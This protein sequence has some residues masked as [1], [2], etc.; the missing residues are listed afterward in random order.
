MTL[1]VLIVD[2][3]PVMRAFVKR[4][5]K[6]SGLETGL[7][8]E[9]GDGKQALTAMQEHSMDLVLTDINMPEMNGEQLLRALQ[10]DEVLR[11]TPVVVVSTDARLDRVD[12][13]MS[14]GASGYVTKPFTPEGLRHEV[15]RVLGVADV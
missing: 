7:L 14:L 8:V 6:M 2:D 3:S 15:E 4:V 1:N 10:A 9:A 11:K 13:M 5:L 12:Q